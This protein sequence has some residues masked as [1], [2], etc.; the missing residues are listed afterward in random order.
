MGVK[1]IKKEKYH[2]DNVFDFDDVLEKKNPDFKLDWTGGYNSVLFTDFTT[3]DGKIAGVW[4]TD[5]S[6]IMKKKILS[7]H[8]GVEF[9]NE[10]DLVVSDTEFATV[11]NVQDNEDLYHNFFSD[12]YVDIMYSNDIDDLTIVESME[13]VFNEDDLIKIGNVIRTYD[14][15]MR[16]ES[17]DS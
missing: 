14:N 10:D 4:V 16:D 8:E 1:K 17:M 13:S 5:T 9:I 2:Y 12:V 6:A 11:K 15:L 7:N 3:K